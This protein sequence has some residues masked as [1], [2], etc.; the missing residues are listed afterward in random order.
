MSSLR[1]ASVPEDASGDYEIV[2]PLM[3]EDQWVLGRSEGEVCHENHIA[4][5]ML[6]PHSR[7]RIAGDGGE[8]EYCMEHW[9][10][11]RAKCLW[12]CPHLN[13]VLKVVL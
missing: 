12:K 8:L 6:E 13:V 4:M 10:I 3:K 11:L 5:I 1:C 2:A 7:V 9:C